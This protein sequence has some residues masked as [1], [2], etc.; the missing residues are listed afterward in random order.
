MGA[1][2]MPAGARMSAASASV[3]NSD[4]CLVPD[5]GAARARTQTS[6]RS[7]ASESMDQCIVDWSSPGSSST[8]WRL[9][10]QM[11]DLP[12]YFNVVYWHSG[13]PDLCVVAIDKF[14]TCFSNT[15]S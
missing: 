5:E 1:T 9:W 14:K 8:S 7:P 3:S 6:V 15:G 13:G 12:A 4:T 11:L 10:W 2:P